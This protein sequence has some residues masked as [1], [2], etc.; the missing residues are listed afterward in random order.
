ME[1]L[2]GVRQLPSD[3]QVLVLGHR[4][5]TNY[6][7]SQI[8]TNEP[9]HNQEVWGGLGVRRENR[10]K[11]RV[12]DL[13]ARQRLPSKDGHGPRIV[14]PFR[15]EQLDRVGGRGPRA[16]RHW[17]RE[18]ES[19]EP[20][21]RNLL[22]KF[23]LPEPEWALSGSLEMRGWHVEV[24]GSCKLGR[25]IRHRRF[26]GWRTA[27]PRGVPAASSRLGW[28]PKG[29]Q[30]SDRKSRGGAVSFRTG[31]YLLRRDKGGGGNRPGLLRL[32]GSVR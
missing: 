10:H 19:G 20:P 16:F 8:Y 14:L 4:R 23:P 11:V 24:G 1:G 30:E 31:S 5:V 28:I 2:E 26:S 32:G 15:L 29:L 22:N 7:G 18:V 21:F 27:R 9:R 25:L 13:P 17:P 12:R 6:P 3:P